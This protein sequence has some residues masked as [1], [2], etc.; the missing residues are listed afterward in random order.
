MP[1]P[2]DRGFRRGRRRAPQ[3]ARLTCRIRGITFQGRP[4]AATDPVPDVFRRFGAWPVDAAAPSGGPV[5][6]AGWTVPGRTARESGFCGGQ[7]GC[8]LGE[9]PHGPHLSSIEPRHILTRL[10][11]A[12]LAGDVP[13]PGHPGR[14]SRLEPA[15]GP[16]RYQAVAGLAVLAAG[17]VSVPVPQV[18]L[19]GLIPLALIGLVAWA[20]VSRARARLWHVLVAMALGVAVTG[21]IFGPDISVLLSQISGGYL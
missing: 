13:R 21:T 10:R 20:L 3:F 11:P 1:T 16:A 19:S 9:A 7:V 6:I 2:P 18:S 5:V 12:R 17:Q 14:A 4:P 15:A 8:Y